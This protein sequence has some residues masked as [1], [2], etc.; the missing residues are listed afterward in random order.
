[1]WHCHSRPSVIIIGECGHFRDGDQGMLMARRA[2]LGL[3]LLLAM[4]GDSAGQSLPEPPRQ[5]PGGTQQR[6]ST[7]Q[8]DTDQAPP[9]IIKKLPAEDTQQKSHADEQKGPEKPSDAWT[10]SDKI[11]AIASIAALLQ[12]FA[13][14]ITVFVLM[15]TAKRQLRAY[16]FVYSAEISNIMSDQNVAVTLVV[17]NFG[18]TPAYKLSAWLGVDILPFPLKTPL[19]SAADIQQIANTNIG[20]GG[21][22]AMKFSSDRPIPVELRDEFEPQKI[23]A[24]YVHGT[25]KYVDAFKIRRF[26]NFRLYKGGNFG[27][28]GPGLSFSTEDNE[29]N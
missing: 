18:Q 8:R 15:S 5:N 21:E 29:A 26:T 14:V 20:P 1:M 9:S 12:F 6:P 19:S 3:A 13:L 25:I 17:K 22:Q 7:E 24:V 11:A 4:I 23:S 27:V 28:T 10:L 16:V 2:I